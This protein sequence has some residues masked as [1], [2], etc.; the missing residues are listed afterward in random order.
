MRTLLIIPTI[1]LVTTSVP[2]QVRA[3]KTKD[4]TTV[5]VVDQ[6]QTTD[7]ELQRGQ[8]KTRVRLTIRP[9]AV[10]DLDVSPAGRGVALT[11]VIGAVNVV[12]AGAGEELIELPS[13]DPALS[14]DGRFVAFRRHYARGQKT[15]TAYVMI[16]V[17]N[18]KAARAERKPFYPT[19]QHEHGLKS[20]I[21]WV[22]SRT[23]AFL[24]FDATAGVT[25][26]VAVEVDEGGGIARLIA[27][28]L[29]AARLVDATKMDA[30]RISP[31][32]AISRA[33]ITRLSGPGL[34][35]RLRFPTD[36]ALRVRRADIQVW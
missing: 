33:T 18:P 23:F 4:A 2:S 24:D 20:A 7:V 14:P 5:T 17:D 12:V 31:A 19:D 21:Q 8:Q 15:P 28:P 36:P 16:D 34:L 6:G 9:K 30:Y 35:L 27:H 11:E 32:A 25:S 13:F 10:V 29:D 1:L 22:D 3:S 26:L